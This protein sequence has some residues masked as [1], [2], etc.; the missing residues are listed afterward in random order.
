MR[1]LLPLLLVAV[2]LAI[3]FRPVG[4][5]EPPDTA[6]EIHLGAG[7][8]AAQA[9]H[10]GG[11]GE[12][13]EYKI[14]ATRDKHHRA[15]DVLLEPLG[16][17]IGQRLGIDPTKERRCLDCHAT[18]GVRLAKSHV[19]EDGVSCELCHGGAKDWLGPHATPEWQKLSAKQKAAAGF[20]DLATPPKR[21]AA[22][23]RCHVGSKRS[24]ITHAIM[25]AGHPPLSGFDVQA[26][27]RVMPPHWSDKDDRSVATW[28]A[29]MKATA[30]AQLDR[31]ARTLRRGHRLEFSVFDC[32]SCHHAAY[33][34]SLYEKAPLPGR[35]GNLPLEL[36]NLKV[37]L[38]ADGNK[39]RMAR[40]KPLLERTYDPR[41][42]TPE[43]L[44][45]EATR[46]ADD[47]A[48]LFTTPR[49]AGVY[50]KN[51][52]QHLARIERN[53]TRAP[54]AEMLLLAMAIQSLKGAEPSAE[55]DRALRPG[56]VYDAAK[57]ARLAR[58]AMKD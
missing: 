31:I 33:S 47:L 22:C 14:W 5:Q 13:N 48:E 28:V 40:F 36:S 56:V 42:D 45:E 44:A 1:A 58:A 53:E 17:R 54:K 26:Y 46:A 24:D 27:L 38:I 18:T 3:G 35:P 25:A 9:C 15:Y 11:S 19:V 52:D 2:A 23:M 20:L 4:A 43:K 34:G 57:C 12:R 49:A 51:L 41:G 55:L 16:Q 32:W 30:R 39:V 10:G 8:C 29:G 7:S 37:L 21:A 6:G 50:L